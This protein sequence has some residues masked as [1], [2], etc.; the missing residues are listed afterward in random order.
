M[1]SP[2]S[3]TPSLVV[4]ALTFKRPEALERLIPILVDQ[5]A[6]VAD[7]A[8]GEVLIVDNDPDGSAHAA[9]AAFTDAGQPVRYVHEPVP[10]IATARNR[11]LSASS[12]RDL[13]VF[14]DDDE[15]PSEHWLAN[16]WHIPQLPQRWGRGQCA[17]RVRTGA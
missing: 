17:A 12:D 9:V 10:G 16:C 14:I 4:A 5:L 1:R 8:D 6:S 11:A 15:T 3:E 13:L 7:Q 2:N